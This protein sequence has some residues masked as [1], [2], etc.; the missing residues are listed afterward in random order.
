MGKRMVAGT[1]VFALLVML[2][3]GEITNEELAC[4]QAVSKIRD[5]C[6]GFDARRM[7]CVES[8]GGCASG[9]AR[10]V[11]TPRAASCVLD[12]EC[13]D[14]RCGR[15]IELSLVPHAEKD[16]QEIEIEACR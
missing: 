13:G 8:T 3:C 14:V 6:E 2:S 5:C 10:P 9:E 16:T 4:E 11:L 1:F 12:R 7:P 15:L